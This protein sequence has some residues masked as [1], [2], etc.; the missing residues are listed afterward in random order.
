MAVNNQE[1]REATRFL[2]Q[3]VIPDFAIWMDMLS[4]QQLKKLPLTEA[5]HRKGINCRHLGRVRFASKNEVA[6]R[7]LLTEVT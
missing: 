6:R 3:V 1:V 5:I 2:F 4:N 7:I